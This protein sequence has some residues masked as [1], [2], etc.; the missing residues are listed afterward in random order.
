LFGI[1]NRILDDAQMAEDVL[2]KTMLKIWKSIEGFDAGKASFFTW[3]SVIARN[4]ALDEKRLKGFQTRQKTISVD[5]I[6]Y[7]PVQ[8]NKAGD[9]LDVNSL[10][11]RLDDNYR[12]VLEFAY[13]KGYTQQE[14]A[15]TLDIPLGT[16]KTRLRAAIGFLREE[17]KDEKEYF[18]GSAGIR[19][20]LM[21][22]KWI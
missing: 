18:L 3:M 11:S 8:K 10:L 14:I 21:L 6:V 1:V 22:L 17:L 4:T 15:D 16:V 12:L 2:Q 5:D 13:L 7:S 19:N 20:L 9:S